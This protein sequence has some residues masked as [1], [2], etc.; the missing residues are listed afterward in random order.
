MYKAPKDIDLV[1]AY[2]KKSK[3]WRKRLLKGRN[4]RG[5]KHSKSKGDDNA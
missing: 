2:Y 4:P 3:Y 1:E 5:T